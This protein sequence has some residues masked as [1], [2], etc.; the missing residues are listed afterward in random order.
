MPDPFDFAVNYYQQNLGLTPQ[1]ARGAVRWMSN[2][3][4]GLRPD[5]FNSAGGGQGALGIAQWRGPRQQSLLSQYGPNPT[6]EQQLA[7]SVSELKGPERKALAALRGAGN[8]QQAFNT[9]GSQYERP[10]PAGGKTSTFDPESGRDVPYIEVPPARQPE[11]NF[12]IEAVLDSLLG[13]RAVSDPGGAENPLMLIDA[14][15]APSGGAAAQGQT[16]GATPAPEDT[17]ATAAP[18]LPAGNLFADQAAPVPMQMRPAPTDTIEPPGVGQ[19][20]PPLQEPAALAPPA[21]PASDPL[22]IIDAL[23]AGPIVAGQF[24]GGLN[25]GAMLP[26]D[27]LKAALPEMPPAAQA[28]AVPG[29]VLIG[30]LLDA[31][32]GGGESLG[33]TMQEGPAS[34]AAVSESGR[35]PEMLSAAMLGAGASVG[36]GGMG[37]GPRLPARVEPPPLASR[38][39]ETPGVA[40][41][42]PPQ[43]ALPR[44]PGMAGVGGAPPPIPPGAGP[45]AQGGPGGARPPVGGPILVDTETGRFPVLDPPLPVEGMKQLTTRI[46]DAL[47][48]LL[49]NTTAD[50]LEMADVV[51]GVPRAARDPKLQAFMA[52]DVERRMYE[53]TAPLDPRTEAFM[54]APRIARLMSEQT[55]LGN[56]IKEML[57]GQAHDVDLP[58]AWQGYVHRKVQGRERPMDLVDP[59]RGRSDAITGAMGSRSLSRHASSMQAR[60]PRFV[61][62]DDARGFRKWDPRTLSQA[63]YQYG[64]TVNVGGRE[65]KVMPPTMREVEANTP[66]RYNKNL[67]ANTVDNVLRLRRVKRNIEFLHDIKAELRGKG[68]FHDDWRVTSQ[69]G[70]TQTRVRTGERPSELDAKINLPELEGWTTKPIADTLN[71]FYNASHGDLDSFLSKANHFMIGSMFATPIPH[72][73]NVGAHWTVGRGWDWLSLPA[74]VRGGKS[75]ARAL[76]AIVSAGRVAKGKP[77]SAHGLRDYTEALRDGNG[78][79]Y[80][81]VATENFYNTMLKTLFDD[82]KGANM[83]AWQDYVTTVMGP[84]HAVADLI[85]A[86]YRWS[87]KTLWAAN[88]MM[89]LQRKFEL[90]AR[91]KNPREAIFEAERDIPNYRV[92]SQVAGS[93]MLAE[94]LKDSNKMN[95]GRYRYGQIRAISEMMKDLLGP[96]S[97]TNM[98]ARWDALGK[99]TILGFIGVSLYPALDAVLQEVSGDEH[100]HVHR[101]GPMTPLSA[102]GALARNAYRVGGGDVPDKINKLLPGD[103]GWASAISSVVTLAPTW[104][105]AVEFGSNHDWLGREVV[106]SQVTGLGPA[107]IQVGE[108]VGNQLM[109]T[110]AAMQ[111]LGPGGPEQAL[112]GLVGLNLPGREPGPSGRTQKMLR[113]RERSR[114][115]RDPVQQLI[116]TGVE[117]AGSIFDVAPPP[118]PR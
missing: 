77:G 92:P 96:P 36:R 28:G 94:A 38:P 109:P 6:L 100:A 13:G 113:G 59:E 63:G 73:G 84:Y 74:Y 8:E 3:E 76:N 31:V 17:Q 18:A 12:P 90:E 88:D 61:L 25:R 16:P 85:R 89:M 21:A 54:A 97:K 10:G 81:D 48:R 101:F 5:A 40:S 115:R 107:A 117:K 106:G 56:E 7:F 47:H 68:L 32:R 64:Q 102:G 24:L 9:F 104:Q 95:F 110:R 19:V 11:A 69:E 60:D 98:Q 57:P 51:R 20:V 29:R 108:A 58:T 78:L 41:I 83:R 49:T 118:G 27:E 82:Q 1:Q 67:L 37:A 80:G 75:A 26:G 91:G 23:L 30:Q 22:R 71:D 52:D 62:Q 43:Q 15:L 103:K 2:V 79:L 116:E 65:V 105:G 55:R 93:R 33:R 66:I 99:L 72:I 14:L 86:E 39:V 46:D 112:G 4:S 34:A 53:P 50:R 87:R 35:G 111:A 114:E 44:P 42:L 70:A 45:A